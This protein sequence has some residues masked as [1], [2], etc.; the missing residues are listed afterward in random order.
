MFLTYIGLGLP[1]SMPSLGNLINEGRLLMM[2]PSQRY[3]LIFPS[4]I[5]SIITI[6]FYMMGN[7]FSDA[8]DPKNHV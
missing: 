2:V 4:I 5:I 1:V 6:S 8:A 3:Q 7:V